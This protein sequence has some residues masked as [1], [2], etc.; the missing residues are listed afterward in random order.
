MTE[1]MKFEDGL[2]QLEKLVEDLESGELDLDEALKRFEKGVKLSKQLNQSLEEADRKV[3]KLL[4][5]QDG[6]AELSSLNEVKA[7][8]KKTKSK[9]AKDA[10]DSLF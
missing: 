7:S 9:K 1:G 2:G 4:I 6:S 5:S 8:P 3:E 10:Q